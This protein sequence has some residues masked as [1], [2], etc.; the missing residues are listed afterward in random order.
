MRSW[1]GSLCHKRELLQSPMHRQ[2]VLFG[3]P[4]WEDLDLI[5]CLQ[6]SDVIFFIQG[7][8]NFGSKVVSKF[9]DKD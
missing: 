9:D 4:T 2:V 5:W 8:K 3:V 6:K 1:L 7:L